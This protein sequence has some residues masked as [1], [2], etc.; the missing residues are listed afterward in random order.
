MRP[1]TKKARKSLVLDSLDKAQ[2]A[3]LDT[4]QLESI[5]SVDKMLTAPEI[6]DESAKGRRRSID[7]AF[8]L[9]R[10]VKRRS[11]CA[12]SILSLLN[13][14]FTG[15]FLCLTT[16][17][18]LFAYDLNNAVLPKECDFPVLVIICTCFTI[19]AFEVV[20]SSYVNVGYAGSFFWVLDV[21]GTLS[22][23]P[24]IL[25]IVDGMGTDSV[26]TNLEVT[27]AG[28]AGRIARSAGSL[29]ITRYARIF[30]IVRL[31]RVVRLLR[32]ISKSAGLDGAEPNDA[33]HHRSL[34][35]APRQRPSKIGRLLSEM[36]TKRIIVLVILLIS[37]LPQLEQEAGA[38]HVQPSTVL[39]ALEFT[40]NTSNFHKAVSDILVN[41]H[42]IVYARVRGVLF[43]DDAHALQRL[44]ETE[45]SVTCIPENCLD[46]NLLSEQNT[47]IVTSLL[48][49]IQLQA[50]LQ[51]A[52]CVFIILVFGT[53]SFIITRDV[54]K[55]I[56]VPIERMTNVIRKL[57]STVCILSLDA[58]VVDDDVYETQLLENVV[59]KMAGMFDVEPVQTHSVR[60][61]SKMSRMFLGT[62]QTEIVTTTGTYIVTVDEKFARGTAHRPGNFT[63]ASKMEIAAGPRGD[64]LSGSLLRTYTS[65]SRPAKSGAVTR[66]S[67][68]SQSVLALTTQHEEL[69]S[70]IS[71]ME[72]PGASQHLKLYMAKS[73]M[74]ENFL[75]YTDVQ[76]FR[77]STTKQARRIYNMYI[78]NKA[79]NQVN[80]SASLRSEVDRVVD[81]SEMPTSIFNACQD[82]ILRLME[83]NSYYKFLASSHCDD[84][85]K[86]KSSKRQVLAVEDGTAT[87]NGQT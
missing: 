40:Y 46:N 22:M 8:G 63:S 85:L 16:I 6:L 15:I 76:K 81:S 4:K 27:K 3:A 86:K 43:K 71:I 53:G 9:K 18:A 67:I 17:L 31:V 21:V 48:A 62:K 11:S 66:Q 84:Y 61:A 51:M 39:R 35:E 55:L 74:L 70:V 78:S 42:T 29:R 23:I 57:A 26:D 44:R 82:E 32:I 59:Q 69:S 41:D 24:D 80:V 30:R 25:Q 20:L 12:L 38:G 58:D 45:K 50:W 77:E 60:S 2:V 49:Q 54:H 5:K 37:V 68:S 72:D 7:E 79:M 56:V 47:V 34:D 75:F 64:K 19:F 73:L 10:P 14:R 33:E 28:K 1:R 65:G 87:Q 36:I 83:L 52:L 13:H